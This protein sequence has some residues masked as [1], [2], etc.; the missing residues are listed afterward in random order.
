MFVLLNNRVLSSFRK[1]VVVFV[2]SCQIHPGVWELETHC[3]VKH[4]KESLALLVMQNG[5][6]S[7][8]PQVTHFLIV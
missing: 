1:G 2:Q 7:A 8:V 5:W 4:G 6:A 3:T